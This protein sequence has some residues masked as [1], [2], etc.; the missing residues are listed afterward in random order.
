MT[1][2]TLL[3]SLFKYKAWANKELFAEMEKLDPVAHQV[4]RHTA[5]R[6]LNHIYVVDRI[7]A[8]HLCGTA[9]SY[10]A[11]NTTETPL[12]ADLRAAVAESDG[13]YVDYVG[14]LPPERLAEPLSFTFTDGGSGRM[15]REE[16][17]AHVATHGG[18][19]RGAVGRIMAELPVAPP[20]DTF[21]RFLHEVDPERRIRD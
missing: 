2:S 16:M 9:H 1:A 21:T 20:R 7:F 14:S 17:L 3:H 6:V 11:T 5:I 19:H 8:A 12:L 10:Q 4:Q 13:W 15:S 18:Y